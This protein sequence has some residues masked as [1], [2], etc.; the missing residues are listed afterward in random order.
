MVKNL[1]AFPSFPLPVFPLVLFSLLVFSN[2]LRAQG[3]GC[4]CT[5]CPQF[6][7]DLFMGSFLINVQNAS[8]PTL[9]QNGQGVCGVIIHFD[10]TAICDISITLTAPSGQTVTLVGPIGQFCTTGGNAGTDWNVTFLPCA[11]PGVSPDPGFSAQWNN[12]QPWGGNNTYSGSYYPYLGCLQNFTGPVNGTWTLTVTDGQGNDVGNLYD[13]EIIFCDPSGIECFTCAAGAGNLVQPDVVAC[14]G[15]PSLSLSLPP[16]YTAPFTAP[17][18]PEYSYTYVVAGPGGVIQAYDPGPDLSGFSGGMYTVCGLSYYSLDAGDIPAPNGTLTLAQL[19]NQLNSTQPP[20]CG[21]ITT[22]CVNVNIIPLPPDEEE[23]QTICGP[24]CYDFHDNTYCQTGTYEQALEQN[25]CPYTA[26]LHLTV[27]PPVMQTLFETVCTGTCSHYPGFETACTQGQYTEH[28]MRTNGCDSIVTLNLNVVPVQAFIS[29]PGTLPCAGG[30]VQLQGN[31]SSSGPGVS[32]LWTASN[33]GNLVGPVN[34]I[35]ATANAPGDY[36]LR[37]CRTSGL[38]TCCDSATV[39]VNSDQSAP[40]APVAII[41]TN[42]VCTGATVTY[43]IQAVPGA[44]YYT[45]TVP[46]GVVIN[47]GQNTATI[48][49]TWNSMSGGQVCVTANNACSSSPPTCLTI[50]VQQAPAVSIPQGPDTMCTGTTAAYSIPAVTGATGYQW[51]VPAGGT[52]LSGQNTPDIIVQWTAA[53]G[54]NVCVAAVSGCGTSP[55]SCLPVLVQSQPVANAGPNGATCGLSF[56]LQAMLSVGSGTGTWVQVGGPG[57]STFATPSLPNATVTATQNGTYSFQWTE[58]NGGC[59]DADT[60]SVDFNAAPVAGTPVIDCDGTGASYTVSF[61]ISGGTS[62]YAIPGGGVSGNTFT[63]LPIANSNSYSFT[64][65]DAV[66][67]TSAAI[68]GTFNCSCTTNAGSMSGSLLQACDGQNVTAVAPLN[69]TLDANDTVA[70][71]LH[72]LPGNALGTVFSQNGS[73]VFGFQPGMA[74][75]STYYISYVVGNTLN[76]APDPADPCFSVS[77]GQPV[78]FYQNPVANAGVDADACGLVLSLQGSGAGAGSWTS[79]NAPAGGSL[80][81]GDAL[82]ANTST[83]ASIFGLYSAIWTL[84]SH[85]CTDADTVALAFNGPPSTGPL[86]TGCD[87]ANENFTVSYSISGGLAPYGVNGSPVAG[88]QFTSAPLINGSSFSFTVTDANGCAATP[89]T[90]AFSC[91]CATSAGQMSL[92]PLS[93]CKGDSITAQ[94]LGGEALDGNDVSAFVLHDGSGTV[95]GQVFAENTTGVFGFQTGMNYGTTYYVSFVVGND[96]NGL[97]DPADPCLDV[98]AGQPVVFYLNPV[99]N[100][101]ADEAGCGLVLALSGVGGA[102]TGQWALASTPAG[103]NLSIANPQNPGTTVSANLFGTYALTYTVT[104]NGCVDKDSLLVTFHALPSAGAITTQCDATN[105]NYTVSFPILGGTAP[106]TVNG[107]ATGPAFTSGLMA[108][109]APYSFIISDSNGCAAPAVSGSVTC[110]CASLAGQMSLTP[111]MACD[112]DTIVAQHLGGENMDANDTSAFVLH[113]GSG[114]ALGTL[115]AQNHTGIFTF[116]NGMAYGTTYYVSFVVGNTLNGGPDLTDPCLSVAAGQPVIFFEQ[117]AAQAGADDA[118]C[119][120]SIT[121]GAGNGGFNGMWSQG[122]G[123]GMATFFSPS[124]PAGIVSVD[125]YGSYVFRWTETNG[126]C[127]S[128]DEVTV[129]FY[130]SPLL[131][132]TDFICNGTNTGYSI[133]FTV[134]GGTAPFSTGLS[135]TFTGNVFTSDPMPNGPFG[136]FVSDANGCSSPIYDGIY[137]CQCATNAGSMLTGPATFCIDEPAT[138]TWDD[139]GLSL[140]ADDIVQFILHDQA[141]A[142][143]GTIFASSDQPSFPFGGALQTGVTYYISAVAGNNAGGQVDL[144]DP[145]LSIAPGTPVLWKPLPTA[146]LSGDA[147][148]CQGGSA[149]LVFSGTGAFPLEITYDDGSGNPATLTISGAQPVSLLVSPSMTTTYTLQSVT[150]GTAPACFNTVNDA[151]TITVS[152]PVQSGIAAAP[153]EFCIGETAQVQLAGL[154]SGADPG[155]AWSETSVSPS[156]PGA[157]NASAGTFNIAGQAAGTYKF[158]YGVQ[159]ASPCPGQSTE[160]SVILHPLPQASAGADQVLD[161]NA[162]SVTLGSAGTAGNTYAWTVLGS[163]VGDQAQL[164]AEVGGDYTLL[165]TNAFGC[166]AT[167]IAT[168]TVDDELPMAHSIQVQPVK[169]RGDHNGSIVLDSIVSTHLPVLFSLNGGPFSSQSAFSALSPGTYTVALQDANG[170]EWTTDT[171]T[172]GEPQP[173]V[174][175]LGPDLQVDL[176]DSAHLAAAITQDIST[177]QAITWNPLLDTL[178]AGTL[179]QNFLPLRSTQVALALVDENGCKASDQVWVYLK[180]PR[181]VYIPNVIQPGSNALNDQLVVFGGKDVEGVDLL[182]VYDR[183]G[184]QLFEVQDFLPND[185][186]KGWNGTFRGDAVQPGVYAY[187]AVVRFIDGEVKMYTGDV[188]V[189]R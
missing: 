151:A 144:N 188:T 169:C 69:P 54:G 135:G 138:A 25:G 6:M 79:G 142:S 5:N 27:V 33:G 155:G 128:A 119:G 109:G 66:G 71:V 91:N 141:G 137:A 44:S 62:P 150:D 26:T 113:T 124:N 174:V 123:Q 1:P 143:I 14:E 49:V 182:R 180:R 112:G 70:F 183:W 20:F 7:P 90:G 48:N 118:V 4:E 43:S 161:C 68:T 153:P 83:T 73:G 74:Y 139:T 164:S 3:G 189:L 12:N 134:V 130:A 145:C 158:R 105:E 116:G 181:H 51:T 19:T 41:G 34:S 8:N 55:Q 172:V 107:V 31:G 106:F 175:D 16:T 57:T 108:S 110:S 121:L 127:S 82:S 159:A 162:S 170:C 184:E 104:V 88:T 45:W 103:G 80:Q 21:K 148:I 93:A 122:G 187:Y 64:I 152:Q 59:S 60:V 39:T 98:A 30:T 84:N 58:T 50:N 17:S 96:L 167:D 38:T 178:H 114:T 136:I 146:T 173:F 53:P 75:D 156:F 9:G 94:H 99:A 36:K 185:L 28:F 176:G 86:S 102:G 157:F 101:G 179:Q 10:H 166:T 97:P 171:L 63:S 111:I 47:T 115:L 186:T 15:D 13:Y 149:A 61:T 76:G 22:N 126:V 11:D 56:G 92:T 129:D 32:Y 117:P 23:F 89:V 163:P 2:P 40:P 154:L 37:V 81:F 177:I 77:P 35:N 24:G 42:Q 65:T 95:L 131:S 78:I 133:T 165:V 120:Q 72:S 46:A 125:S 87:A 85:G 67:C 140:D 160:V 100:A 168:V 52:I 29:P 147:S 132:G 18:A